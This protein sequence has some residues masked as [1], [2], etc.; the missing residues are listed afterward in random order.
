MSALEACPFLVL[1]LTRQANASPQVI[2]EV[3]RARN[4]LATLVTLKVSDF[5]LNHSLQ[6]L[7]SSSQ[8]IEASN[9]PSN[10]Q[11]DKLVD[12]I[13]TH[14]VIKV[15]HRTTVQKTI[16][17]YGDR[18]DASPLT[19]LT[20]RLK[21]VNTSLGGKTENELGNGQKLVIGRALEADVRL[22]DDQASRQHAC[23][24]VKDT[25]LWLMD[26]QSTN[27]TKLNDQTVTG[28]VLVRNGDV[29]R[30]GNTEI[31]V[32]ID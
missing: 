32:M 24:S 11:I 2:S 31:R 30:I 16:H 13:A 25:E 26:M 4:R 22:Q 28:Q 3:E 6:Y 9:P 14:E 12:S 10:D 19:L 7:L 21:G 18:P 20:V 8:W 29:I 5:I 1:V 23:L 17:G 27:G 15:A